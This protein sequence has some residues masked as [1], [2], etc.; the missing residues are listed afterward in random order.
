[1]NQKKTFGGCAMEQGGCFAA[2]TDLTVAFYSFP[3]FF[4]SFIAEL[5]NSY[6]SILCA[7]LLSHGKLDLHTVLSLRATSRRFRSTVESSCLWDALFRQHFSNDD[8]AKDFNVH[9]SFRHFLEHAISKH[10][11]VV[12]KGTAHG[13]PGTWAKVASGWSRFRQLGSGL[14]ALPDT[15]DKNTDPNNACLACGGRETQLVFS[16]DA[17]Y[18]TCQSR[19]FSRGQEWRCRR[20]KMYSHRVEFGEQMF[21]GIM[22]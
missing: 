14:V 2:L 12:T 21:S 10:K 6:Q 9:Y 16:D 11:E 18:N 22:I 20:C 13:F 1:M 19:K 7:C 8:K 15:Y 17:H 5:P 4:L 3:L